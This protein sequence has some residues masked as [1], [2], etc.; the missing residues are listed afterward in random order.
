MLLLMARRATGSSR[1]VLVMLLL[2]VRRTTG[3]S[4]QLLVIAREE[5]AEPNLS[6]CSPA[7]TTGRRCNHGFVDALPGL[8][9]G[10]NTR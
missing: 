10:S 6:S 8:A 2:I 9:A 4:L 7:S 5:T 3:T 1:Q